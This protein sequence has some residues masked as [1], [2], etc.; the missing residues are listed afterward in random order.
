MATKALAAL[1]DGHTQL[2][3]G[4]A[5]MTSCASIACTRLPVHWRSNKAL[6][7]MFRVYSLKPIADGTEVAVTTVNDMGQ[8]C[9][10]KNGTARFQH[11]VAKFVD[12]R[13]NG[14]SGRGWLPHPLFFFRAHILSF[15]S[16]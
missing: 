1:D 10:V 9:D 6:P 16:S 3:N 8:N 4:D 7:Q 12:M 5:V 13:F 11:N 14:K 2:Q 15:I